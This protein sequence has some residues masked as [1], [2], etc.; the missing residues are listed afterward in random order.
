[1]YALN[2]SENGRVLSATFEKFAK[3]N[4]VIVKELPEGN[5][6]DYLY[7][8][9]AFVSNPLPIPEE[10]EEKPTNDQRITDLEEGFTE[11]EAAVSLIKTILSGLPGIR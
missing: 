5:I 4:T 9:G 6:S 1:M 2:I 3:G 10:L 11:L 7:V 8:D